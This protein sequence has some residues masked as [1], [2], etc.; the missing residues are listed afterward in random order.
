M[1]SQMSRPLPLSKLLVV[2]D[3]A[4]IRLLLTDI[5]EDEGHHVTEADSADNALALLE[6]GLQVHAL[7]TDIAMPGNQDG[8]GLI[9]WLRHQRPDLPIVVV[10][11]Q[12]VSIDV[13]ALN[14]KVAAVIYKPYNLTALAALIATLVSTR[15]HES[16]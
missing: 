7:I 6:A 5:L 10:T 4:I 14:P 8:F 15:G 13:S 3:E 1:T 16:K 9:G 2:E 12:A 11:G